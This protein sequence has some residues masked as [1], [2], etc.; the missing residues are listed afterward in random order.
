MKKNLLNIYEKNSKLV[1][2]LQEDILTSRVKHGYIFEGPTTADK[3]SLAKAFV[4]GILCENQKGIGCDICSVCRKIETEQYIDLE[5]LEETEAKGSKTKSVKNE[6]IK[7]M[8]QRLA[9]KPFEGDRNVV[10]IKD[11]QTLS[12]SGFNSLLKTLEEPPLGAVIILLIE[13]SYQIPETIK[14]RCVKHYILEEEKETKKDSEDI[15]I[16]IEFIINGEA[17]YKKK[18]IIDKFTENKEKVDFLLDEMEKII[19][20]NVIEKQVL[21]PR[22]GFNYIQKIEETRREKERGA[23]MSY[24]IK[25][26]ILELEDDIN[27]K[28][29]RS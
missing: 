4:K 12:S 1:R 26:L 2:K 9:N 11:A 24:A 7:K 8:Q 27:E 21:N 6:Q 3:H 10:I 5:I 15:K 29:S 28:G 13:N 25:K 18:L 23:S 19:K 16:L 22:V 20:T 14:S 17:Y